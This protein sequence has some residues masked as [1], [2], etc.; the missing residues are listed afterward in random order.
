MGSDLE[1]E[2][3]DR[4]A[5]SCAIKN[6]QYGGLIKKMFYVG[7]HVLLDKT[8]FTE[9]CLQYLVQS[10]SPMLNKNEL[11]LKELQNKMGR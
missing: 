10:W 1:I 8:L 3:S 4:V 11:K 6:W 9:F 2:K 5:V 7:Y